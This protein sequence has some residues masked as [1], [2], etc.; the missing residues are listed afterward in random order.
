MLLYT[1]LLVLGGAALFFAVAD[2]PAQIDWLRIV[3]WTGLTL[4]AAFSPVRLPGGVTAHT[5]TT[6]LIAAIFDTF[7]PQPLSICLIAFFGTFGPRDFRGEVAF[8][9]IGTLTNRSNSM[10]SGLAGWSAAHTLMS[11]PAND[12]LATLARIVAA[13]LAFTVVNMSIAVM[14]AALRTHQSFLRVWSL[15][16]ANVVTATAAQ[17]LLGWLMA[18]VA[19]Q[20][21]LWA[22]FMVMIPLQLARYSMSKYTEMRDQFFGSVS[23][24]SQAI[25]AK[26][27]FTRGHADRV[28]RIAGAIAREMGTP[29]ADIE[30]IELAALL[31]DIGKIAVPDRI[32]MKPARLEPDERKA[33][34]HH[35]LFGAAILEPSTALRPLVPMVLHH[36]ENYDG[37]GYPEGLKGD[38][39]PFGSRV[40]IVADAY[41]AMTSD[42]I[43]RKAPGHDAAMEQLHRHKGAQFDPKVVRALDQLVEK[44]G[45]GAFE[46]SDLPPI[47]YETLE[48]L[49]RRLGQA[50]LPHEAHTG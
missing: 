13:G 12:P 38:E 46:V 23:A 7:L 4:I 32:L 19:V 22:A 42:R 28:S 29:E 43:Y 16:V 6:P 8:G 35:P 41:E 49:R 18:V 10:L 39:I 15:S 20:I 25:D 5:T 26:D 36:H 1:A 9:P 17:V 37:T 2:R 14:T 34:Q 45:M 3:V 30:R 31:H 11:L 27:G 21:G 44:R 24:L 40:I 47:N 33:M 48:E 50:P